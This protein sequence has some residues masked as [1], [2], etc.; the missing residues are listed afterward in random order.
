M[1]EASAA[2][3]G[4]L[5]EWSP[6]LN[7]MAITLLSLFGILVATY[8]LLANLGLTG[9]V[10]CGVGDCETVQA[11]SYARIAGVP[12]SAIGLGGYV[13]LFAL[14]LLGLQ[15]AFGFATWVPQLLVAGSTLGILFTGYLTY[16]EAFVLHAWCQWCVVS[17]VLI[18]LIFFSSIP[19]L[20]R[21]RRPRG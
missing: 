1:I 20:G 17:A 10:V 5:T 6:P 4:R 2:E 8:L 16:I 3:A 21:M 19:E 11:S 15:P 18:T 9:P 7:R 14:A 13:L 12:V